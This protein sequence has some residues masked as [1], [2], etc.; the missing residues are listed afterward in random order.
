MRAKRRPRSRCRLTT[1]TKMVAALRTRAPTK[2]S[3]TP[4]CCLLTTEYSTTAVSM[5]AQATLTSSREPTR[6]GG[7]GAGAEDVVRIGPDWAIETQGRDR[8]KRDQIDRA[9]DERGPPQRVHWYSLRC[10]GLRVCCSAGGGHV[11]LRVC[12]L[13]SRFGLMSRQS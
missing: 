5:Q 10:S 13:V 8:D 11:P 12:A 6:I 1:P 9:G 7:I 2:P 3:A 4:S